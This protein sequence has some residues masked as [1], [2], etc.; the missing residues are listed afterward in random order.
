MTHALGPEASRSLAVL[1]RSRTLLAFDFDGTLAPIVGDRDRAGMSTRTRELLARVCALYPCAVISGRS[2][3]DV[4]E[5]VAG[6]GV[7]H[8]VGNH[9]LE[10][11]PGQEGFAQAVHDVRGLL[12]EVFRDRPGVDIEDKHY[13]LAVHYRRAPDRDEACRAIGAA[14]AALPLPMRAVPGKFVVNVV[15]GGAPDKGDALRRLIRQEGSDAALY[16]GD[17]V[18]DEDAFRLAETG[19]AMS[20]RVGES[21]SSAASHFV[22]DREEVDVLLERLATLREQGVPAA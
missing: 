2:R 20:V 11:W 21:S 6:S 12:Q 9:G 1:A 22:R 4:M 14:V 7:R 19:E 15:P 5:R 3:G 17:D 13:T 18:T 8:V 10:P 16:V